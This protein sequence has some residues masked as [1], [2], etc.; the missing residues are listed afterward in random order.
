MMPVFELLD[1]LPR[2]S[3]YAYLNCPSFLFGG[4]H[5]FTFI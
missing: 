5:G 3:V 4:N 2:L 1:L